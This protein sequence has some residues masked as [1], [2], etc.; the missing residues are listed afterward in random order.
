MPSRFTLTRLDHDIAGD[1]LELHVA[2]LDCEHDTDQHITCNTISYRLRDHQSGA[3]W[4]YFLAPVT[5]HVTR[6]PLEM[7]G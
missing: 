6:V 1:P 2:D 7:G 4:M 5:W 3:T